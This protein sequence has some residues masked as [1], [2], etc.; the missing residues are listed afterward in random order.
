VENVSA[1]S[2]PIV[3]PLMVSEGHFTDKGIPG[4][5]QNFSYAYPE[6]GERALTPH[7]NVA[8]WIELTAGKELSY[9]PVL[10]YDGEELLTITIEDAGKYHGEGVIEICP[11]VASAF[12]ST[13]QAFSE[14]LWDGVPHRGDV[15]IICAHPS[16]GHLMTF[17]YI[18]GST[19]DLTID[20]WADIVNITADNYV[21][22][23]TR[24][25]TN[26]SVTICV[27]EELFP[28]RF[29]ELRTKCKL[30]KMG[31]CDV[32]KE[33]KKAFKMFKEE[34]KEKLMYKHMDSVFEEVAS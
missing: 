23:F 6:E 28:E 17:E 27:K 29:F 18:L 2:H 26:D 9:P 1:T 24:K 4:L 33:E 13:L 12:R 21:Y 30:A 32:T 25:S 16:D 15:E 31:K 5:L 8:E 10:I 19:E 14:D 34:L 3:V 20:E 22:T 7:P 11:C